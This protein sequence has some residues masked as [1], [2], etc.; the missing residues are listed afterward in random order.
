M[1]IESDL[2]NGWALIL[3]QCGKI[4]SD[5]DH[6]LASFDTMPLSKPVKV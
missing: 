3:H 6:G 2:D 5:L 4:I 1:K